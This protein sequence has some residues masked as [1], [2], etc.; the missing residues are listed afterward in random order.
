M[1]HIYTYERIK[2][3][4]NNRYKK[5]GDLTIDRKNRWDWIY[6][7]RKRK[8]T[9]GDRRKGA[10]EEKGE[11]EGRREKKDSIQFRQR[12]SSASMHILRTGGR[13]RMR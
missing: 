1:R 12:S 7:T 8:V 13:K 2:V 5:T 10:R 6:R 3:R 9:G 4:P 11:G